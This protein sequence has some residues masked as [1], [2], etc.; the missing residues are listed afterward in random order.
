MLKFW[1][2]E[3]MNCESWRRGYHSWSFYFMKP[4][5]RKNNFLPFLKNDSFIWIPEGVIMSHREEDFLLETFIHPM[6]PLFFVFKYISP[7]RIIE[8]NHFFYPLDREEDGFLFS[9]YFFERV[10]LCR[11]FRGYPCIRTLRQVSNLKC[12]Q[13]LS[14]CIIEQVD[15]IYILINLL[16]L[17]EPWPFKIPYRTSRTPSKKCPAIKEIV[18][19][20]IF[21]IGNIFDVLVIETDVILGKQPIPNLDRYLLIS[22]DKIWL[23]P[24]EI[25]P[26]KYPEKEHKHAHRNREHISRKSQIQ[27]R[28]YKNSDKYEISQ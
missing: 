11:D 23:A 9:Y 15:I 17:W 20:I 7:I 28:E 22:N 12:C 6:I 4:N 1:R 13:S 10:L 2:K 19:D 3:C 21:G 16:N 5:R 25:G 18:E 14:L 24:E 26:D 8:Q 27:N